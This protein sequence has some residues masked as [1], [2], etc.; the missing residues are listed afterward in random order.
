MG[1]VEMRYECYI[2]YDDCDFCNECV[3]YCSG[4][5]L[6]IVNNQIQFQ[7]DKCTY[8]EVCYDVCPVGAIWIEILE[9]EFERMSNLNEEE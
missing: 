1:S 7:A 2:N 5:A 6:T 3:K 8:C 9:C 4:K